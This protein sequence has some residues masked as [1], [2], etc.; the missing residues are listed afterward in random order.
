MRSLRILAVSLLLIPLAAACGGDDGGGKTVKFG[1]TADFAGAA[2]L[3]AADKLGLWKKAGLDPELKV[4]T[5]GP[6][7][8]Q[9]LGAGDFDFGY[10]GPGATWPP[11]SGKA[12]IVAVNMLGQADRIIAT[13]KSGIRDVAG[14]RGKKVAVPEGTSGDMLL[15]LALKKAQM[16]GKD[17]Q[18]V[19][20]DPSTVVTA[21]S[22][23]KV[24]AAAI[25]YPLIDTIKK[26][27]PDLVELS[28]NADF[29]PA[30]S[31]P[32]S[33][34]ARNQVVRDDS[35][36]VRKVIK[37]L[38]QANDWV[39]GNTAEAETTAAEFLKV[40]PAQLK[41]S[42]S[43]TKTFTSAELAKLSADGTVNGWFKGLTD[44]FVAMGKLSSS[45][46]PSGYYTAGL[47][48]GA[49]GK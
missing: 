46:D 8:I 14:L 45:P 42:S 34:V 48:T 3:A 27:T 36:T 39:H 16:T 35:A 47:Y 18:K 2:A 15:Q 19:P 40:P 7:Q 30:M 41:G 1:Y 25:W 49:G 5:N 33:F 13:P 44:I 11:A 31:F 9:A 24:D 28:K 12:K 43:V 17:A 22:S 4:F 23:G 6:L 38:Q 20:M 26:R 29:Y 32:S 37:V 21:F 10:I